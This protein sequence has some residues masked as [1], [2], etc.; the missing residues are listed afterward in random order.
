LT[1]YPQTS[2]WR[3]IS[4]L[5]VIVGYLGLMALA[6]ACLFGVSPLDLGVHHH[7]G[8][9]SHGKLSHS[10]LCAWACQAGSSVALLNFGGIS[11]ALF[12]LLFSVFAVLTLFSQIAWASARPR[13]PPLLVG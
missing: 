12:L 11:L 10:S 13:S 4:A 7:H 5:L 9:A 8:T 6:P 1:E 2:S 3:R